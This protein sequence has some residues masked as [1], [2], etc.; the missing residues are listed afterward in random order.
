MDKLVYWIWLSL[1]CTPGS[2]T[3]SSLLQRFSDAEEIYNAEDSDFRGVIDRKLSDRTA[4]LDKNLDE[5][6][7]ILA[8]CKSKRVG[9]VT[10][11]DPAFPE[12]LR[13]ISN[14]P[15]LLYYRG[16]W[17][18]FN[19][20]NFFA[21]IVGT[22]SVSDYGRKNTF[23]IAR[24]LARAG[25]TVVSGMAIGIDGVALAGALS[26]NAPTV[27]VIGSG[28]DVC[29]PSGHVTLAREIVKRGCV[30]TEFAPGT[31]P[32]RF[33]FPKRNRLISGL[34]RATLVMEG[35][36]SS[37]A[38]ITARCAFEQGRSVYA[39]PGN[40]GSQNSEVTNLLLKNGARAFVS[41]DD[42][43]RDFEKEFS[44]R[45]NPF[46]LAERSEYDMV[47]VLSAFKVMAVA[48]SDNIFTARAERHTS[49]ADRAVSVAA[50]PP[51]A[52]AEK[53]SQEAL[54][55][56]DKPTLKLYKKIPSDGEI[57]I[58]SLV[59]EETDLRSVMKM[60]LKLEM[61]RFVI[62]LPGEKVKRNL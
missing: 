31:P 21:A 3:F 51:R 32:R 33:N 53:P 43:V 30:I 54:P 20:G 24:D 12:S 45:L 44:G 23:V 61:G 57:H 25:A 19:S 34:S 49:V 8:F 35:R 15:V 28:I 52:E 48:P 37:G 14:P 38:L 42:I 50:A 10:Y 26:V 46:K 17:Q 16:V 47:S 27:A 56:F 1:A 36:E 40:V 7:R 41:A 22:R 55:S 9:I 58:E 18:D 11:S 29:Y 39:L 62:M 60:L 59:D 5:A 13:S 4:L 6:K 2:S